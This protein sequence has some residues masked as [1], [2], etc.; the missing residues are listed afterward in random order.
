M[1][2]IYHFQLKSNSGLDSIENSYDSNLLQLEVG[3]GIFLEVTD[4]NLVFFSDLEQEIGII[5]I[6]KA[7]PLIQRI[8]QSWFYSG[9]V[10]TINEHD[11]GNRVAIIEIDIFPPME[12]VH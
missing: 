3:D 9:F 4:D 2:E 11:D 12:E 1:T 5:P 6:D 7:E 8:H 10:Q